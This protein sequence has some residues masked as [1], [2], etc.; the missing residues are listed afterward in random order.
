M[1][2]TLLFAHHS[3]MALFFCGSLGFLHEHSQLQRSSQPT[4]VLLPGST[5]Q[6]PRCS[7]QPLCALVDTVSGWGTQGCGLDHLCRS[8][9]VLPAIDQLLGSPPSP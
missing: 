9:S 4:A 3:T 1:V 6:A 7:T 2:V 8:H 5:L